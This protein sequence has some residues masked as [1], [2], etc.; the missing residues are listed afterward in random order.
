MSFY[1]TLPSDTQNGNPGQPQNNYTTY[2]YPSISIPQKYEVAL[3]EFSYSRELDADFGTA[4][5]VRDGLFSKAQQNVTTKIIIPEDYTVQYLTVYLNS[6]FK[7]ELFLDYKLESMIAYREISEGINLAKYMNHGDSNQLYY[8]NNKTYTWLTYDLNEYTKV[9]AKNHLLHQYFEYTGQTKEI[10]SLDNKHA[11]SQ[12]AYIINFKLLNTP[13]NVTDKEWINRGYSH[14]S[15]QFEN[16]KQFSIPTSNDLYD[17]IY[18]S[19]VPLFYNLGYKIEVRTNEIYYGGIKQIIK[20]E[21]DGLISQVL[22]IINPTLISP[23]LN[24]QI[25]FTGAPVTFEV[26]FNLRRVDQLLI[27]TDIIEEQHYGCHKLQVLHTFK[28]DSQSSAIVDSP[29]YVNVN[30]STINSIN[31]RICDRTG[32][33]VKFRNT[34]SNV[35]VKLHFRPVQ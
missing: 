19:F 25:I 31:I 9:Q 1:V 23:K 26:N 34:Y 6:R 16:F 17:E 18:Q 4:T 15:N 22:G 10:T 29:H 28:F 7:T 5:L 3:T 33:P 8:W 27:Y 35:I 12:T 30:K 20:M 14:I 13:V 32:E 21:F 2:I 24:S 11:Q